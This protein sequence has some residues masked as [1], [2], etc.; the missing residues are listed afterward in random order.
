M[1]MIDVFAIRFL[2]GAYFF[3]F[4]KSSPQLVFV[5]VGT[6]LLLVRWGL[7][8]SSHVGSVRFWNT[9]KL[10]SNLIILIHL[11]TNIQHARTCFL[12]VFTSLVDSSKHRQVTFEGCTFSDQL[13]QLSFFDR[14]ANH[15]AIRPTKLELFGNTIGENV[16]NYFDNS[17]MM[18]L[19][20]SQSVTI[21]KQQW[22]AAV[23]VDFLVNAWIHQFST[24]WTIM[25]TFYNQTQ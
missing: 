16:V 8:H 11:L 7:G 1:K 13:T 21:T 9:I 24:I 12:P 14:L 4:S 18:T 17:F 5:P 19:S 6:E 23:C 3:T 15:I 10:I 25:R 2:T 20:L 22:C